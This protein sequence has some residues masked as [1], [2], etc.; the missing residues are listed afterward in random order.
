[1]ESNFS[2]PDDMK[3]GEAQIISITVYCIMF[4]IGLTTNTISLCHLIRRN[5]NRMTLL[6]IHLAVA[7]LMVTL[8]SIF[9]HTKSYQI[10]LIMQMQIV[11]NLNGAVW[12]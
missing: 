7:D 11:Q 12:C 1:M 2:L 3:F 9:N 8:I 4:M 10:Y 5:R 6:L